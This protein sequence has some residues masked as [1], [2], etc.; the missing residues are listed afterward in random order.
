MNTIH[1]GGPKT[2]ST[3]LQKA[4]F[5]H[6]KNVNSFGEVGDG[7]TT[8]EE[9][10]TIR[11]FLEIDESFGSLIGFKKLIESKENLGLPILFSS[12]DIMSARNPT[13]L[14]FRLKEIFGPETRI[15]LV[16]RNQF[17][18]LE[19][20]YTGHAAWLKQVPKSH[21]RKY[22]SFENW[23]NFQFLA[24]NYKSELMTFDYYSQIKPYIES[25]GIENIKIFLFEDLIIGEQKTWNELAGILNF[26]VCENLDRFM[27]LRERKR[28]S[29]LKFNFTKSINQVFASLN[30]PKL[31]DINNLNKLDFML[32]YGKP[33]RPHWSQELRNKVY[34]Y[35]LE[36][37]CTLSHT[38]ELNLNKYDYPTNNGCC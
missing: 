13:R 2:A 22:T 27:N 18:C 9:E 15:I 7:V 26:E 24:E 34:E 35:Y 36:G 4:V 6:L 3:N 14:A 10:M 21:F 38:F 33:Y 37:N 25:F 1:I 29:R 31:L 19:S 32:S 5:R 17:S 16:M 30:L 28:V 12:A 23:M 20:F 8:F 11:K